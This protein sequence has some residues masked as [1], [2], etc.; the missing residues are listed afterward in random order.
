MNEVTCRQD[1]HEREQ[2]RNAIMQSGRI[3]GNQDEVVE[4]GTKGADRQI[5]AGL[6]EDRWNFQHANTSA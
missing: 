5:S 3:T 1:Q 6:P 2:D 4:H